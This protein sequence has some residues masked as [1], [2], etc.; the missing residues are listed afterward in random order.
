MYNI[1]FLKGFF[2]CNEMAD[3]IF[4]IVYKTR[5]FGGNK[6]RIIRLVEWKKKYKK[7]LLLKKKKEKMP[8]K[9][10]EMAQ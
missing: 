7:L 6:S 2:V 10:M 8:E 9:S 5:I 1:K 4:Y 3:I